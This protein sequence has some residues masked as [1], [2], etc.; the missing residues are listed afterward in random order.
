MWGQGLR[1]LGGAAASPSAAARF[2]PARRA[3]RAYTC[4]RAVAGGGVACC[5]TAALCTVHA[6]DDFSEPF[7]GGSART[8]GLAALV[9]SGAAWVTYDLLQAAADRRAKHAAPKEGLPDD[10]AVA[11][12]TREQLDQGYTGVARYES[13]QGWTY[14]G[15]REDGKR[16]GHGT[17]L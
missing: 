17:L 11:V 8:V 10:G 12:V 9:A 16:Q 2:S 3:G 4:G 5:S 1:R 15:D 14:V 7:G 6:D 13:K